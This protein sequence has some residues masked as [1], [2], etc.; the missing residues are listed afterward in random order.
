LIVFRGGEHLGATSRDGGVAFDEL[1]HDR[2]LGFDTKRKRCDI[3]KENVLHLALEHASLNGSADS[4]DLIG[5]H[6]LVRIVARHFF[7]EIDNSR[8]TS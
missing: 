1:G 2:T 7:D 5:V 4:D 6:A 3:E 8:H